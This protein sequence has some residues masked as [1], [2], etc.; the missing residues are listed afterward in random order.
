MARRP[1]LKPPPLRPSPAQQLQGKYNPRQMQVY[2]SVKG[3]ESQPRIQRR[4][5]QDD[6]NTRQRLN[7][8]RGQQYGKMQFG[9]SELI[10]VPMLPN[11]F[12][13]EPN[14]NM[15]AQRLGEYFASKGMTARTGLR[16]TANI[17]FGIG[18]HK[19]NADQYDRRHET[20]EHDQEQF[21]RE[22]AESGRY[23]VVNTDNYPQSEDYM[24]SHSEASVEEDFPSG[25]ED[26]EL[27]QMMPLEDNSDEH[28]GVQPSG[29]CAGPRCHSHLW[30]QNSFF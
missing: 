2:E 9:S 28:F 24:N 17:I 27:A 12:A 11:M 23:E 3:S 7:A 18:R 22:M 25:S 15:D 5:H 14:R 10:Y 21:D 6:A 13:R 16:R 19:F 20:A 1:M 30:S 4:M 29:R 26:D 8:R